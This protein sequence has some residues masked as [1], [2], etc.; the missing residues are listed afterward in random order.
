[1]V[2]YAAL[3]RCKQPSVAS[4]YYSEAPKAKQHNCLAATHTEYLSLE[5]LILE[6]QLWWTRA[7]KQV[8]NY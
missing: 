8:I 5:L 6:S 3:V 4:L 2:S 7:R 1:M